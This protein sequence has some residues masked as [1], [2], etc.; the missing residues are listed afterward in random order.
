MVLHPEILD[1]PPSEGARTVALA[2]LGEARERAGRLGDPGDA[3]ALHDFRVS[4]RR[5][6]SSLRAWRDALGG[7]VRDKDLRRLRK[8]ARATNEA[9]DAEV[10]LAW[11]GRA[12]GTLPPAHRAA[13]EWLSDR[14]EPRT[15]GASLT[16]SVERLVEAADSLSRRLKRERPLP[17]GE[18]FGE[19]IATRIREQA[20]AVSAWL[21]RVESPADA[22]LA[23]RARIE[24]KR[25]RYLLEPLRD[26][27]G[28]ES[29]DA[30]KALKALQDL[31]GEL[32]DSRVAADV[33]RAA[34]QEAERMHTAK[35]DEDP[36]P[37][38]DLSPGLLALELQAERRAATAYEQLRREVL[39][40]QGGPPLAPALAV[41]AALDFR[42]ARPITAG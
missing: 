40:R 18:T 31:L 13:A 15:R 39:S 11:I 38:P 24:G 10:L 30:V 22:P 16:A 34:R 8:V 14:L 17:S 23:H 28:V 29:A 12:A 35:P 42:A 20:A 6:R 27:P 7:A 19:A 21:A 36:G 33:L 3:S 5:L 4:V 1:R 9:R 37:S 26:T 41:A 32:N 25:L 2:F